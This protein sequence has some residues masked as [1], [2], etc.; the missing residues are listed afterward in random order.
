MI[1]SFTMTNKQDTEREFASPLA[2]FFLQEDLNFLVTNRLPR[3]LLTQFAGWFFAIRNRYL[4]RLSLAVWRLF[5]DDL[6][7]EEAKC[8]SFESMQDCFTRELKAGA[9]PVDQSK[10]VLTSPCDAIIGAHGRISDAELLQIKDSPYTLEDLTGD[11]TVVERYR[12]GFF[13]TLR[14]QANM[15]HRFHAPCTG[16]IRRVTYISGDTWNVNPI[17]LKRVERLFCKNERAMFEIDGLEKSLPGVHL[18]LIPVGAILVASIRLNFVDTVSRVSRRKRSIRQEFAC[19]FSF[20]KGDELG[21]FEAGST[22]LLLASGPL[23]F[24]RGFIEGEIIRMGMPLMRV[25]Q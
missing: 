14:L 20:F 23:E 18:A 16:T 2:K 25:R 5:A 13:I 1:A 4:T 15:Y 3:G 11:P 19:E 21:R 17:A 7:L 6:R 8:T 12:N 9:R 24:S 10:D 22:I